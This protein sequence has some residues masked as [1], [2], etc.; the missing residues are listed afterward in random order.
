MT[1]LDLK[2]QYLPDSFRKEDVLAV[3]KL[4]DSSSSLSVVGMPSMGI[5][6]FLR[7]LCTKNFGLMIHVDIYELLDFT[8]T[9][10]FELLSQKLGG[11]PRLQLE[12]LVKENKRV[13]IVFNRF[14]SL[15]KAYT[16]ELFAKLRSLV[17]VDREKVVMIFAANRP[18]PEEFPEA[19]EGGNLAKFSRSYYLKPYSVSDL[20]A[21]LKLN[22]PTLLKNPNLELAIKMS[23]G[24]YQLLLLLFKVEDLN[25]DSAVQLQCQQLYKF[26]NY[27]EK[28][29]IQR[30]IFGKKISAIDQ[31]LEKT[32]FIKEINGHL[33]TFSPI[34]DAFVKSNSRIKLPVKESML[35][36]ILKEKKGRV[37][38]KDEL[39]ERLW[40]DGNGATDW[41]LSA[42]V[43]RLRKN[44]TFLASGYQIENHKKV[45]YILIR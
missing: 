41:A 20:K 36:Q 3:K 37:L 29:Q 6:I 24:H 5:S 4:I 1:N 19:L 8:Q 34:F 7:Y 22:S 18:I 2:E 12:K 33:G 25:S 28:K 13:V 21:L 26:L 23:G 43:Y 39:F 27:K 11:D 16:K 45:G 42:L 31:F 40:S 35:F 9:S 38:S 30:I 10:L 32:G 44:P 17:D 15:K 14:D